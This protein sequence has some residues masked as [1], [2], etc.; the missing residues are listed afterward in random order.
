V[1]KTSRLL[2][3]AGIF[4]FIAAANAQTPPPSSAFDGTY[5]AVSGTSV[6]ATY[7]DRNGR[8]GYCPNRK[9]GPL[10]VANGEARYTTATGYKLRG[11]VGPQ[12]ELAMGLVAPSNARNAGSQ[13]LNLS[14]N[15]QIDGSGTARVR[16]TGASCSYDF[17]WQ[18]ASG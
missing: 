2:W 18:K 14:T 7:T 8:T 16:Q 5:R 3:G 1:T 6:N 10:H 4:G 9:P 11:T 13:P 15:G 12:G 17:V